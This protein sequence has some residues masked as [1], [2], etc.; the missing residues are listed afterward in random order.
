MEKAYADNLPTW[1]SNEAMAAHRAHGEIVSVA[2][3]RAIPYG[4]TV[5]FAAATGVTFGPLLLNP[6]VVQQL[7]L[8][9]HQEGS[10]Q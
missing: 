3:R 6:L 8:L 7:A 4:V 2:A 10:S 1:A 5:K 9:L